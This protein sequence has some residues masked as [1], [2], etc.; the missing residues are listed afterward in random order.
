DA[1]V[2]LDEAETHDLRIGSVRRR[3]G[4]RRWLGGGADDGPRL[5]GGEGESEGG[6]EDR[7][8]EALAANKAHGGLRAG[9]AWPS[10]EQKGRSRRR[11]A[12]CCDV[13]DDRSRY[14]AREVFDA[15]VQK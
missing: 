1:H 14:V 3:R 11:T 12:C 10:G 6:G 4:F 15:K 13:S 8:G 2:A 5:L 9:L 7:N